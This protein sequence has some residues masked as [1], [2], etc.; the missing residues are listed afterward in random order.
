MNKLIYTVCG[1]GRAGCAIAADITLQGF[2]VNLFELDGFKENIALI[3]EKGGIELS[4]KTQSGKVGF[5]KL[6]L[7][8]TNPEEAVKDANLIMITAPAFGHKAFFK[9]ILPYLTAEQCVLVNTGYWASLRFADMLRESGKFE[10]ITIAE[11]TIMPYISDKKGYHAHILNVKKDIK[12]ATFPGNRGDRISSLIRIVYPQH[13]RAPNVFWTN[14]EEGNPSLHATFLLPIAGLPFD[15]YKG[16]KIY[17]EATSCG[18]RLAEAFDRERVKIAKALGC[19]VTETALEGAKKVYGYKGKDVS[20]AYRKSP[21][22]DRYIPAERLQAILMEDLG[23][24]YVPAS[25]LA[26]SLGISTPVINAIVEVWGAILSTSY[27]EK[28]LTLEELRLAGL[29]TDQMIKY[30]NTGQE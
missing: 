8:T 18:A 22:A 20:E 2:K 1:A 6:N 7:I 9:S 25:R 3:Q 12:F 13:N 29:T 5:A 16:C 19:N 15:R 21:H 23:Y 26:S 17:G 24:F 28:G 10:N 11:A 27:W 4:G 14:F 30:V